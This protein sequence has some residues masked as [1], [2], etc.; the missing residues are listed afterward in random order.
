MSGMPF[1][2]FAGLVGLL[3]STLMTVFERINRAA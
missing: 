3:V 2:T 1:A